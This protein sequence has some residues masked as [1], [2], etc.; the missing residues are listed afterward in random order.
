MIEEKKI[1]TGE[2]KTEAVAGPPNFKSIMQ[3]Q[4]KHNLIKPQ[5]IF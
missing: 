4:L 2:V 5:D 3:K 1:K